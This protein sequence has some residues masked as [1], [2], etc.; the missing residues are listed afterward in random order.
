MWFNV[1]NNDIIMTSFLFQPPT[2]PVSHNFTKQRD[3]M[4]LKL[5]KKK[6]ETE[7]RGGEEGYR[8]R[9]GEEGLRGRN[10]EEGYRGRDGDS[11]APPASYMYHV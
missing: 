2:A 1:C 6:R 10:G 9:N 4:R 8:G 5:E 3:K 11:K 7:V